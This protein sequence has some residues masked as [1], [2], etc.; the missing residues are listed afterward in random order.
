MTGNAKTDKHERKT[1]MGKTK[2]RYTEEE[3][4]RNTGSVSRPARF[5]LRLTCSARA[6]THKVFRDIRK[7]MGKPDADRSFADDW[8]ELLLPA[9]EH[10]AWNM[11]EAPRGTRNMMRDLF[12][13]LDKTDWVRNK[14]AMLKAR[15][16]PQ[17]TFDFGEQRREVA[18]G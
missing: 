18:M 11:R 13:P 5:N 12:Q 16:D 2:Y 10:I 14:Y 15:F 8:E 4:P 9:L 3:A 6:R 7:A 1:K 17:P